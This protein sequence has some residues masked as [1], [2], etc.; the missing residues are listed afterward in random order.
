MA[1]VK[2]QQVNRRTVKDGLYLH[3]WMNDVV[4]DLDTEG[5]TQFIRLWEA[6]IG[7]Q[8]IHGAADMPIW[9]W[10]TTGSYTAASAYKMMC[11]GGIKFQSA[12][13]IWKCK[14][15]LTCQIFM[16]L[17]LQHRLWTS[18]RRARHGLQDTTSPCFLCEQEED[19]VDH[20]L[21]QCVFARQVWYICFVKT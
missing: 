15:P 6:L 14:A 9:A 13:A 11:E 4:G 10:N 18:D 17:A 3:A 12:T 16:W 21:L 2:T 8:L 1:K 5:L 20:I 19:T 7:I